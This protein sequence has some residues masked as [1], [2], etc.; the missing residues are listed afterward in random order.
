[1]FVTFNKGD[2]MIFKSRDNKIHSKI[3]W[4]SCIVNKIKSALKEEKCLP[5]YLGFSEW[6]QHFPP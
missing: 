4:M 6:M 3:I 5:K 1:M 2:V